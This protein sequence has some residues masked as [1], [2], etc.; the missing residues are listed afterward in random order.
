MDKA[1]TLLKEQQL[2]VS[3]TVQGSEAWLYNKWQIGQWSLTEL[4]FA[5]Y[6]VQMVA[7]L[8]D[9]VSVEP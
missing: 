2:K 7:Y 9:S 3:L 1:E 4:Y 5:S 6:V 8:V